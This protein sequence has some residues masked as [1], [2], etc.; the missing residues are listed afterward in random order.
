MCIWR[1]ILKNSNTKM[2]IVPENL[3]AKNYTE[4]ESEYKVNSNVNTSN[5][6]S[7]PPAH[8]NGE[9]MSHEFTLEEIDKKIRS[10]C[11]R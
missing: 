5:S 10:T 1:L 2:V 4:R 9:E 8:V 7:A 3:H 6:L 11:R